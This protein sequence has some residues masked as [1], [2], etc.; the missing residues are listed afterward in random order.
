MCF[1]HSQKVHCMYTCIYLN[2]QT[3]YKSGG[4]YINK[5]PS[6]MNISND[7]KGNKGCKY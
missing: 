3:Y 2:G 7:G 1:F 6:D 4:V 5:N